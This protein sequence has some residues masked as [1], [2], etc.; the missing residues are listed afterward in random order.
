MI[1]NVINNK[2]Y[3]GSSNNMSRRKKEHFGL[4]KIN[5]HG[6]IYMQS[7]FNKY[8]EGSF[9]FIV[10]ER[11]VNKDYLISRELYWIDL[12]DSLNR[13]KG[14]NLSRPIE[15]G[16]QTLLF[17]ESRDKLKRASYEYHHG[18]IESELVYNKWKV[19]KFFKRVDA[20]RK[21]RE[22][23]ISLRLYQIDKL[24]GEIINTFKSPAD[25]A[26]NLG[27]KPKRV[28]EVLNNRVLSYRGYV[29]IYIKNYKKERDYRILPPVKALNE[30]R[31]FVK[32]TKDNNIV[33]IYKSVKEV[34]KDHDTT[35]HIFYS[36]VTNKKYLDGFKFFKTKYVIKDGKEIALIDLEHLK[37]FTDKI[38]RTESKSVGQYS[39]SGEFIAKY[40]SM[41]AAERSEGFSAKQISRVCNGKGKTHKGY[42]FKF[43]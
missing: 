15:G 31:C 28:S 36:S 42:I 25:A 8:G 32:L 33:K 34:L 19:E 23:I 40:E 14:Y 4:L 29:F 10:L 7:S 3:I 20:L 30:R 27:M 2:C 21:R 13:K 26:L 16:G 35:I 41:M 22:T 11:G 1:F 39:L 43:I 18:K 6:N 24:T 9:V 38:S 37:G 17:N 5:K 12:K